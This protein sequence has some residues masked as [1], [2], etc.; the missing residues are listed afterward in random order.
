MASTTSREKSSL[1]PRPDQCQWQPSR[2]W[3]YVLHVEY[4][5]PTTLSALA[6]AI[7]LCE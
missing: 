6:K 5:V 2:K 1:R 3:E 4:P 7:R